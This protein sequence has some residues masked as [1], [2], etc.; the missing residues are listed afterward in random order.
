MDII[1][2]IG[3]LREEQERFAVAIVSLERLAASSG[4]RRRGRKPAW[5]AAIQT[6]KPKRRGRPPGSRNKPKA[7]SP[8]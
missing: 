4:P 3:E 5:L 6:E 8:A 2:V 7:E 1:K